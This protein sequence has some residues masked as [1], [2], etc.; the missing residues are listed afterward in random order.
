MS[1]KEK[2][3]SDLKGAMKA[4]DSNRLNIIRRLKSEIKN[5]EIDL[6][7]ELDNDGI[8]SI[9]STQIKKGNEAIE[10]FN[11]GKRADLSE[12]EQIEVDILKNYLPEQVSEEDLRLRVQEVIKELGAES[13]SDLGRIMKI[14][15]PEFKGR[16]DNKLVKNLVGEF[17]GN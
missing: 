10:L 13:M 5:Q 17:L 3:L 4:K 11:K 15:V 12:K 1:L 2:L 9:I 8:I 6:K 14:L 7:K 16:A